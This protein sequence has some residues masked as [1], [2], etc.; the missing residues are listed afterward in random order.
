IRIKSDGAGELT[1]VPL[2]AID[3]E[4]R[5]PGVWVIDPKT[6]KVAWRAVKV[7]KFGTETA[8]LND[9]ATPGEQ[10]VAIGGHYLHDGDQV[11]LA[12]EKAAMR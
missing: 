11:R 3:D 10:I 12:G 8:F 2:G 4:G 9:G 6:L 7:A 1:E 5:G